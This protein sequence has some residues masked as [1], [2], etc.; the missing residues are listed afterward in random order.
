MTISFSVNW[1]YK[2][3]FARNAHEHLVA[4][5]KAGAKWDVDFIPFSLT[6]THIEEGQPSVFDDPDRVD[7]LLAVSTGLV[8]KDL[9]PELFLDTHLAL[10]S[11]RHD[12]GKNLLEW[13]VLSGVLQTKGIDTAKVKEQIDS[14]W[15]KDSYRAG[16]MKSVEEYQVFGVPTFFLNDTATFARIMT[17]PNG[18]SGYSVGLIER[19]IGNISD[20]PELNEIKQTK[21]S[22]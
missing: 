2:C 9:Y 7:D 14:G 18:D 22:R 19:I 8:V 11:A 15:P 16:H 10:F 17:R 13:E 1:D 3:P 6:Q 12:L 21:V 5:L 4:A 20:F